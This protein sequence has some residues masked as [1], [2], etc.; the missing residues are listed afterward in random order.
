MTTIQ[1]FAQMTRA[2]NAANGW[3]LNFTLP[4]IPNYLALLHSEVTEAYEATSGPDILGELADVLIRGID[5]CELMRPGELGT[6]AF[7]GICGPPTTLPATMPRVKA[8]MELNLRIT[9][10]LEQYRKADEAVMVE[11]VHGALA[12]ALDW[13]VGCIWAVDADAKPSELVAAKIEK[14]RTRG[15]RHGGRRT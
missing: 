8:L 7:E 4:D 12:E 9:A 13:T 6:V 2:V 1:E 5:L 3:G 10:A 11:R 15:F 14:N